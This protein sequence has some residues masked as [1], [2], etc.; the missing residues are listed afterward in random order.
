LTVR[1]NVKAALLMM[2]SGF[3]SLMR[4]LGRQ[5]PADCNCCWR[6]DE[7]DR[8]LVHPTLFV[9]EHL[10]AVNSKTSST[11]TRPIRRT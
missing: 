1:C 5:A 10:Q 11:T 9:E 6:C 7:L 8:L 3:F 2:P 4:D